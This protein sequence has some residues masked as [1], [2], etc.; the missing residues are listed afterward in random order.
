MRFFKK[1]ILLTILL[2]GLSFYIYFYYTKINNYN[3]NTYTKDSHFI[4][5]LYR[6]DDRIYNNYLN[7]KEKKMYDHII[8]ISKRY[9][10]SDKI[11][12]T[13]YVGLLMS[14]VTTIINTISYVLIAFV[15]ISLVVRPISNHRFSIFL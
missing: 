10:L 5:E 12:Y 11:N 14:S 8:N 13:D 4:S 15:S 2:I 7:E 3:R 9:A 6:S 1:H